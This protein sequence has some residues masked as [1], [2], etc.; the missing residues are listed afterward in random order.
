MAFADLIKN[1]RKNRGLSLREVSHLT[2]ISL[3]KL[4]SIETGAQRHPKM[5]AIYKL[6]AFYNLDSDTACLSAV[7]VPQDCFYKIIR[8]PELLKIIRAYKE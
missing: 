5:E 1:A 2:K 8:C 4:H 6:V 3:T 7:R